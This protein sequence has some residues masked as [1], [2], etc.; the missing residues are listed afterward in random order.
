MMTA[1]TSRLPMTT[2]SDFPPRT[3]LRALLAGSGVSAPEMS[4]ADLTLDS[5]EV[6]EGGAFVALPGTRTH[7]LS[8]AAQAVERGVKVILWEPSAGAVVPVLPEDVV[9]IAVPALSVRLGAIADRF[10]GE[11]SA[12]V[13]C[14]GVTGT[15]GKTTTAHVIA[16]ALQ[17]LGRPSAYAGT[18]GVG[19]VGALDPA[20]HTTPDVITT[21]RRLAELRDAGVRWMAMEVSSHALDQHR[22]E[23]VRFGAAV[24]TNL[25]RDH[26]DYHGT[27][28]S[29]GAAKARLLAWPG[30][31]HAVINAADDFGRKLLLVQR[32]FPVTA[33]AC[34]RESL[35]ALH[36][37]SASREIR[38]LCAEQVSI[39]A[40]GLTISIGGSWG[41]LTLRSRFIGEFNVENLLAALA[42]LLGAGVAPQDA[43]AA[44]EECAAPPGRMETLNAPGKP[45][46]IVDY[47]HTPD[48]LEK[49]L[50]AVRG[51]GTGRLICVFGCGGDRDAGKRPMMAAIA[52]RLADQIVITDDNPRT[53]DGDAI[54][55]DIVAGLS[56]PQQA[57]VRRDRA[58]AIATAVSLGR[59]GDA[60]LVAGKGH[61]DYQIVGLERRH[62]SDREAALAALGAEGRQP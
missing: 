40:R 43:V 54:V 16:E 39:G 41:A 38:M 42:V 4:I 53:E 33:F 45:M 6:R 24:F 18:L 20:S 21:H 47:A 12:G 29:Y 19:R 59:E 62:F 8:F 46:V 11:P 15:N 5:R 56:R 60:V 37:A 58:D 44:L 26:L 32:A 7:G 10:F 50:L 35:V 25:T 31:R 9:A 22:V 57:L 52:E 30:L 49:A 34:K 27:F 1:A 17:R 14:I 28:E 2:R 3:N 36:A 61:E 48:A 13:R 55:A 51:H 23:A